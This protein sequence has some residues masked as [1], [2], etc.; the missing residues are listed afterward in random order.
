MPSQ[1]PMPRIDLPLSGRWLIAGW[2]AALA[3]FRG[4]PSVDL[5]ISGLFWRAGGGFDVIGNPLWEWLRQRL[6]EASLLLMVFA[7]IAA[8]SGWVKG[9]R[10]AGIGAR[11][12]AFLFTLYLI[13]PGLVVNL[14]LKAHSGRA[15][16]A[17]VMQFGGTH[18]FTPAGQFADQCSHNCSFVSGEVSAA[19]VL[20]IALW[21]FAALWRVADWL[22]IYL[23]VAGLFVPTFIIAQRVVTGRHFASDAGFSVLI[24]LSLGWGLYALI[25]GQGAQLLRRDAG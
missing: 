18:S 15:R 16:P 11:V 2:L 9:R 7:A 19:A 21:L 10:V 4:A 24:T 23:R 17:D 1:M 22:R 13:G 14:W 25:S 12:W 20:G 3:L 8:V 6:W 5:L